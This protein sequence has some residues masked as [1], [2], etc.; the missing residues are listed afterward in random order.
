M[1]HED[2][3]RAWAKG[4]YAIEAATELLLRAFGGSLAQP[5]NP[6]ICTD[7]ER[8]NSWINFEE[9]PTNWADSPVG[10]TVS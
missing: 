3:L 1:T 8:G 7:A 4:M 10:S 2:E 9:T 5:G 6:W